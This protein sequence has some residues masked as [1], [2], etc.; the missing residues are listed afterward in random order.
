MLLDIDDESY[1][2]WVIVTITKVVVNYDGIDDE[3]ES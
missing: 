3:G 1:G 2:E